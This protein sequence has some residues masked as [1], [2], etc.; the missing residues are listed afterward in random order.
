M[1]TEYGNAKIA[2]P[3]NVTAIKEA[4]LDYFELWKAWKL[5]VA[6]NEEFL[7]KFDRQFL[8]KELALQLTFMSGSLDGEI[9]KLRR[10]Y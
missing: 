10:K 3:E 9:K 6:N 1:L 8:S 5:P 4:L 2:E 7:K